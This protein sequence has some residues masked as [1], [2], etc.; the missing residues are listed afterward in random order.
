LKE[1][2]WKIWKILISLLAVNLSVPFR[3][4]IFICKTGMMKQIKHTLKINPTISSILMNNAPPD[5]VT[6]HT[7]RIQIKCQLLWQKVLI[8]TQTFSWLAIRHTTTT[9]AKLLYFEFLCTNMSCVLQNTNKTVELGNWR[10]NSDTY[11]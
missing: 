1:R 11:R 7:N 10:S 6:Q 3:H 4:L 8:L 5:S 9:T 2:I